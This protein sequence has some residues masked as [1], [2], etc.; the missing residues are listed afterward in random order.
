MKKNLSR[1][2]SIDNEK[3]VEVA[4]NK[5]DLILMASAR[6]R[7]ISRQTR[8]N[9]V[10]VNANVSALLEIQDGKIGREYLSKVR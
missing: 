8:S 2:P 9:P 4:G 3:C 6:S 5:Y 7:E 1:G 10:Y